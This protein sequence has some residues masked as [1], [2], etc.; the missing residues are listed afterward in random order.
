GCASHRAVETPAQTPAPAQ[1]Q[2]PAE[3]P[4][5]TT[6]AASTGTTID[7]AALEAQ[8]RKAEADA[9]AA[10]LRSQNTI[11]FDFDVSTLRTED[12]A[13]LDANARYLSAH[14]KAQVLLGGHTDERGT[15]EYNMAL[16]ERRAKSAQAYLLT[17]GVKAN[18]LDVVSYGEEKPVD[19]DQTEE[20]WA[21]NRRVELQYQN[22]AP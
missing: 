10:A 13:I 19:R 22:E 17:H 8:K 1:Q 16:G 9:A 5:A 15:A 11:H 4:A 14:P 20:A 3:A 18:Q 6:S 12:L 2:K 7:T 21:K